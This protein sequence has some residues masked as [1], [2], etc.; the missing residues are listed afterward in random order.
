ME[1]TGTFSGGGKLREVVTLKSDQGT[2]S[3]KKMISAQAQNLRKRQSLGI[4]GRVAWPPI[5]FS[6]FFL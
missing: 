4:E 3:R 5:P 6:S 2:F 1:G